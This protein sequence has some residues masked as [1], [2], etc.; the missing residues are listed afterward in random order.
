LAGF[1]HAQAGGGP[2]S[3]LQ[4]LEHA[5]G[6]GASAAWHQ[7]YVPPAP[8][9]LGNAYFGA[10]Q[11]AQLLSK[12]SD[13]SASSVFFEEAFQA[14][15]MGGG[16]A[17]TAMEMDGDMSSGGQHGRPAQREAAAAAANV[18]PARVASML[19]QLALQ[20]PLFM[21]SKYVKL[22]DLNRCR[23][24]QACAV[25]SAVHW[26]QLKPKSNGVHWV[27]VLSNSCSAQVLSRSY[28]AGAPLALSSWHRTRR[29][30]SA[31][32]SSARA[33][34]HTVSDHMQS[35]YPHGAALLCLP[36]SGLLHLQV[37]KLL[38]PAAVQVHSA[39]RAQ[40]GGAVPRAAA[41]Q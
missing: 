33:C 5:Q 7:S 13:E 10:V 20:Q 37:P 38:G 1:V 2:Y 30:A 22:A 4:Q 15:L 8:Q 16:R 28:A 35:L 9:Q 40:Q 14:A 19:D 6:P 25:A 32:P 23:A 24:T 34:M 3:Q 26:S 18:D 39:G 41:P 36:G 17:P 12:G 21:S 29:H 11:Q 27:L 31:W